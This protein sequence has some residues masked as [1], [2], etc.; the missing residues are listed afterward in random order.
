MCKKKRSTSKVRYSLEFQAFTGGLH[1]ICPVDKRRPLYFLKIKCET[2]KLFVIWL[3]W[4]FHALFTILFLIHILDTSA[5]QRQAVGI[6]LESMQ[7][8]SFS[9]SPW[10]FSFQDLAWLFWT[11]QLS[12]LKGK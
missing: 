9:S 5:G 10:G 3:S 12:T 7:S 8:L 6:A 4:G 2:R 1:C 11:I